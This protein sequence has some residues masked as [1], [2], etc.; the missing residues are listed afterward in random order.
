MN[1]LESL[2]AGRSAGLSPSCVFVL[3][4]LLQEE[5]S[6]PTELA[7]LTGSKPQSITG[8]LDTLEKHRFVTRT[9]CP[10]D[11]R[12]LIIAPTEKAIE[13]FQPENL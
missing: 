1:A 5:L 2:Q 6:S 9:R 3:L 13:T 7:K 4:A 8:L 11:R 12:G 10:D